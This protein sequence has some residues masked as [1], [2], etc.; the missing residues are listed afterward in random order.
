MDA[1]EMDGDIVR[2]DAARCIGCGLCVS[3][4]PTDALSMIPRL[5]RPHM[6]WDRQELNATMAS[7]F[8]LG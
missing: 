3:T 6:P 7:S 2:R 4:C 8:K 5:D 1:L